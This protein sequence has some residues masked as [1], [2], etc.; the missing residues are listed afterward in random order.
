MAAYEWFIVDLITLI[1]NLSW[2]VFL[3]HQHYGQVTTTAGH[4]FELNVLLNVIIGNILWIFLVDLDVFSLGVIL[5]IY[6]IGLLVAIA[7]SQIETMVFLRTLRV[8]TMMTNTAAKVIMAMIMFSY[9]LTVFINTSALSPTMVPQ[10]DILAC[11][12][13][14]AAM[15]MDF[16]RKFILIFLYTFTLVIVLSVMGFAVFRGIQIRRTNDAEELPHPH[17][18]S[19]EE[20]NDDTPSQERLFTIQAMICELNQ[21]TPRGIVDEDIVIQDIEFD[22]PSADHTNITPTPRQSKDTFP[23]SMNHMVI[24]ENNMNSNVLEE[25]QQDPIGCTPGIN[26]IMKTIQKYMKNTM[27]SL[28]VVTFLIPWYSTLIFGFISN[29]GCKDPTIKFIAEMSEYGVYMV[30]IFLPLVIKLKLDRLSE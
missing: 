4:V 25:V 12:Y 2:L 6:D 13:F 18:L 30:T 23:S 26:I 17:D 21:V 9:G 14:S 28:L 11:A 8:N 22:R 3:T 24:D 29:S 20:L 16:K 15:A 1:Y 10:S 19:L 5:G 27:M 7:G